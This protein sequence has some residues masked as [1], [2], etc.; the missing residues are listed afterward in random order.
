MGNPAANDRRRRLR[1]RLGIAAGLALGAIIY[2]FGIEPDRLR[3]DRT[4]LDIPELDEPVTVAVLTDLHVGAP[5]IDAD[6]LARVVDE[7]NANEPDV[8]VILGDLV[9]HGVKG[10]T[11]VPP[12][13]IAEELGRLQAPRG[14]YAVLGNHDWWY[15]GP[16]V[17]AALRSAGIEVLYN[18]ALPLPAAGTDDGLWVAGLADLATGD[19]NIP[20][21]LHSVPE[22]A[23]VLLLTHQPDVFPEVPDR[24]SVTLAGHTH[25]GQV[26][27]P[28]FGA[29]VVPSR[30]GAR[31][32]EGHIVEDGRHLF[33]ST[34]VGTSI[35]PVRMFVVPRVDILHLR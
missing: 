12:E 14:V 31:Y 29:V 16:R 5:H 22:G 21:T 10:G 26:R 8:I 3:V 30:Y 32:A 2:G 34:G 1:W 20:R 33:V 15:D 4:E 13:P 27:V 17:T 24:V 6:K 7:T 35:I 11:F 23:P 18:E 19:T 25:G 9:I 28:F